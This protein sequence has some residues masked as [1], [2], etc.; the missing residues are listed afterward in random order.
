[1]ISSPRAPLPSLIPETRAVQRRAAGLAQRP[2]RRPARAR[3][4]RHAA[5]ARAGGGVAAGRARF[6]RRCAAGPGHART[7][8]RRAM[9]RPGH[10][11]HRTHEARRGPAAAP[12]PHGGDGATGLRTMR[13]QLSGLFRRDFFTKGRAAE[14]LRAR[15]QGNRP[16]AQGAAPGAWQGA[17]AG[18]RQDSNRDPN[19]CRCYGCTGRRAGPFARATGGSAFF[20]T[21]TAQ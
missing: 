14:S 10:G 8:R 1:M 15:R 17:G 21:H 12:A 19:A 7:G 20:V 3:A 16:H 13:I 9:A 6:R 2:V 5:L 4:R 11:A 18:D